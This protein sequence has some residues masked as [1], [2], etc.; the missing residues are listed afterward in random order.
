ME[1]HELHVGER[2]AGAMRDGVAVA[3]GD[4]RVRR[5]AIHLAAAAGGEHGGVGD[6]LHRLA[7]D[8][9]AHADARAAR[10]DEVEHARALEHA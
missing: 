10:D 1:L 9:R 6:D 7:G 5:V 8:A 3:R 4:H 2:H